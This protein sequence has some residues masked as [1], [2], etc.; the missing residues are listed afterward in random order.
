MVFSEL[1]EAVYLRDRD[2]DR[3]R[4]IIILVRAHGQAH[5]GRRFQGRPENVHPES[6]TGV[7][8]HEAS[9][10][11]SGAAAGFLPAAKEHRV[12]RVRFELNEK[13]VVIREFT[14]SN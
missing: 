10:D 9:L 3:A 13:K 6:S 2:V 12:V 11:I 1:K 4:V 14:Y 5:R 8:R 7:L